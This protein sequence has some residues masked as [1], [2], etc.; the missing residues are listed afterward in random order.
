MATIQ[1]LPIRVASSTVLLLAVLG[2]G[3]VL[4]HDHAVG[5]TAERM[6]AMKDMASHMKA[7]G[8]LL[9]GRVPYDA[10]AAR[11]NALALHKSCHTVENQFPH[12]TRDHTTRASPAIW[13]QPE[14][15]RAHMDNLQ[16]LVGELVAATASG[17]RDVV[18]SRFVDVGRACAS[19]HETFRLPEN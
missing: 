6:Q 19:C 9:E 3:A 18:R 14:R 16:Q 7:L 8:E 2:N 17:P 15:F 12:G 4:A 13:E 5:V 10:A 11:E 1:W